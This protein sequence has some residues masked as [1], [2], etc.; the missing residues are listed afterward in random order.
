MDGWLR[1]LRREGRGASAAPFRPLQGAE[2]GD[3]QAG[4]KADEDRLPI[5]LP[6]GRGRTR[7]RPRVRA[8]AASACMTT[9]KPV[10]L[11]R[12]PAP[13]GSKGRAGRSPP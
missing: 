5:E 8:C 12:S 10:S 11:A 3:D 13:G 6:A 9:A 2:D 4:H 7:R 1:G